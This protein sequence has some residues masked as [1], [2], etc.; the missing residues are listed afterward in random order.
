MQLLD[1]LS[2]FPLFS[3]SFL[4]DYHYFIDLCQEAAVH[5]LSI[6]RCYCLITLYSTCAEFE[7][8]SSYGSNKIFKVIKKFFFT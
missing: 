8:I 4:A 3:A 1:I 7:T 6:A 2:T 5:P